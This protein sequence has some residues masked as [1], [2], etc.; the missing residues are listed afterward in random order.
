MTNLWRVA[1]VGWIVVLVIG[2]FTNQCGLKGLSARLEVVEGQNDAVFEYMRRPDSDGDFV[3]CT[4]D[5]CEKWS[6][7]PHELR[8]KSD[9]PEPFWLGGRG[10]VCPE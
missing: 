8:Y 9:C 1:I 3:N 4:E 10:W 5:G 2:V 6:T 7:R